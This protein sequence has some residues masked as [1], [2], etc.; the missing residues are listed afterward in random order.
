MVV[1]ASVPVGTTMLGCGGLE[2]P[3]VAVTCT[4][5]PNTS[6]G[7][8]VF[9]GN[10]INPPCYCTSSTAICYFSASVN[11]WVGAAA[12][13]FQLEFEAPGQNTVTVSADSVMAVAQAG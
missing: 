2:Y 5:S 3:D 8:T 4:A 7:N 11:V 10:T 6:L 1:G 12:G 13:T 9:A